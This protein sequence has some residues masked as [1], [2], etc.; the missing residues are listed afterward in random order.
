[1]SS[2]DLAFGHAK[3]V[4]YLQCDSFKD[5]LDREDGYRPSY[6]GVS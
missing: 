5:V 2:K 3:E 1:V 6:L 4:G